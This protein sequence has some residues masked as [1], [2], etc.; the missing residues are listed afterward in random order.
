MKLLV[1]DGADDLS[2]LPSQPW[3]MIVDCARAPA[4]TYDSWA[5]LSGAECLSFFDFAHG[6]DDLH[7]SRELLRRGLKIVVDEDGVD[8]WDVLSL[9]IESDLR[10]VMLALRLSRQLP[11]TCQI[12][13]SRA[14]LLAS[15]LAKAFGTQLH[16]LASRR[17]RVRHLISR[18]QSAFQ[19]LE[20]HQL[21]Q[22]IRDK[23]DPQHSVR[24]HFARRAIRCTA[25]VVLLPSAYINVSRTAAAH[26]AS[27]PNTRFLLVCARESARLASLPPNVTQISLN[28]Y[29]RGGNHSQYAYLQNLY[30]GLARNLAESTLEYQLASSAGLLARVRSSLPCGLAIRDSWKNLLSAQAVSGVLCADDSNPYSRLPLILSKNKGLPTVACHH[31]ALD[32]RMAVKE[33]HSDF[34]LTKS[35]MERDYLVTKCRV[36]ADRLIS[37]CPPADSL[38]EKHGTSARRDTL[39]FFSEPLANMGW[40][41]EE[42]FSDLIPRLSQIAQATRLKLVLKLHPFE[43]ARA[44]KRRLQKFRGESECVQV[45]TGPMSEALWKSI[46]FAVTVQSSSALECASR[47]IPLILC[48]WLSDP[49]SDYAAQF[50]TFGVG[51]YLHS[52]DDLS[53][54]PRLIRD[55]TGVR[56]DAPHLD[57]SIVERLLSREKS[58][59][60]ISA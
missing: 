38:V 37:A 51:Q 33:V 59:L 16:V 53:S 42:V 43:S 22:V 36:S 27:A 58:S 11:S 39:V 44:Y 20:A 12:Y 57:G 4:A 26:A 40:R 50:A 1:L 15:A 9:L 56:V 5:R 49:Y 48:G 6:F 35:E 2:T 55:S 13:T 7:A 46:Q 24:R 34:Y 52:P 54:I 10:Q 32:F 41:E 31:G 30:D 21:A 17:G 28:P 18:Y 47:N 8:W 14:N 29:F 3:D 19:K 25:P 45:V 60:S 23:F